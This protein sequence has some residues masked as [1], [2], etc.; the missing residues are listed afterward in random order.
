[1]KKY[2]AVLRGIN[3]GGHHKVPMAQ[4]REL[5]ES[6]GY[7]QVKTL[8]NSGNVVFSTDIENTE[9]LEQNLAKE[10][11]KTFGFEIPTMV[12]T[13]SDI[14]E[15]TAASPFA[16]IE[17]TSDTR[18]YVTFVRNMPP[19]AQQ[20]PWESP[21]SSLK[22]IRADNKMVC[23]VLDV[24]KSST[25]DAMGILEKLYTKDIT[26]RNWN[27]ILKIAEQLNY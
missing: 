8:L 10:F 12:R 23:S 25:P 27:T 9:L 3:V 11:H 22:I 6:L 13:E 26:T 1:M 18:F 14:N 16:S 17:I 15:L 5:F 21:L 2:V 7:S 24:S 19:T 20:M 4:L